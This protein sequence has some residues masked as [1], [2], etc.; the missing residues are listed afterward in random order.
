MKS[1]DFAMQELER[2]QRVQAGGEIDL[3]R[4]PPNKFMVS[5]EAPT[6]MTKACELFIQEIA[7]RAWKH[8]SNNRRKTLQ[9]ADIHAAVGDNEVFDFLI[10]IVPRV[11]AN[12][13]TAVSAQADGNT[14][15]APQADPSV[16]RAPGDFKFNF[17]N[18]QLPANLLEGSGQP[19]EPSI[20]PL[21]LHEWVVDG[22]GIA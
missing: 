15:A 16:A 10:D 1:E 11:T 21:Q 5:A 17:D 13:V 14:I 22:S 3:D 4:K 12:V 9:R 8:T 20:P 18:I 7:T 6:L 19:Q 2:V